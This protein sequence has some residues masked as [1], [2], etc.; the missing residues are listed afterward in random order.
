MVRWFGEDCT[1]VGHQI[2][3]R[4]WGVGWRDQVW[5][6]EVWTLVC[7]VDD[8]PMSGRDD[9]GYLCCAVCGFLA[10]DVPSRTQA[11]S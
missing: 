10:T 2:G 9:T 11:P 6:G 7:P 5:T 8:L 4:H 1:I 3:D